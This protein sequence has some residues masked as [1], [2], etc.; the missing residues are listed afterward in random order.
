MSTANY[1]SY[2]RAPE[3]LREGEARFRLVRRRQ[4]LEEVLADEVDEPVS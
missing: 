2:P 4:T 3:V 1:N